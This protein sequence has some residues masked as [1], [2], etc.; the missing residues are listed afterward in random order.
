MRLT[1]VIN[2]SFLFS[3]TVMAQA[4]QNGSAPAPDASGNIRYNYLEHERTG[5]FSSKKMDRD[6]S[7][8]QAIRNEALQDAI[9]RCQYNEKQ[10]C[11]ELGEDFRAVVVSE[12]SAES[13]NEPNVN[14]DPDAYFF[15]FEYED[16]Q[17][18][19]NNCPAVL[20]QKMKVLV[21]DQTP[22]GSAGIKDSDRVS[23]KEQS[24][25]SSSSS[26]KSNSTGTQR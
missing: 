23:G 16:E 9:K 22:A 10:K 15:A 18:Y 11:K 3:C 13:L 6:C 17:W 2:L 7:R 5:N 4:T 24:G 8:A 21:N 25:A 26:E 20:A 1:V 14:I 19:M 12:S